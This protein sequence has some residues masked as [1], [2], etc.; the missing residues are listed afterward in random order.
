MSDIVIH[1]RIA[2]VGL[3]R[4]RGRRGDAILR[5]GRRRLDHQAGQG[6]QHAPGLRERLA[7]LR[8]PVLDVVV[9]ERKPL[10]LRVKCRLSA[11][12]R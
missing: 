7:E 5:V 11:K 10:D 3:G 2:A 4:V 8:H 9:V 12:Q 6:L 1:V